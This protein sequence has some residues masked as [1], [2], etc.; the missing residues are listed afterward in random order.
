MRAARAFTFIE[1]LA[2]LLVVSVGLAAAVSMTMYAA[3]I[4]S[5]CQSKATAM[6][7][8]LSVSDDPAPLMHAAQAANWTSAGANAIGTSQGW[9][10]G[11]YVVRVE[12][13]GSSPEPGF[14]SDPVSVDVYDGVRGALVASYTTRILRQAA[15]P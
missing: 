5:R 6:A 9:V 4:G 10:N 12:A 15:S 13:S 14:S 3:V 8:A 11:Y 7:T 2:C 1:V